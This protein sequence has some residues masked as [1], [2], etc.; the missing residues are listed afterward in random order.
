MFLV[1]ITKKVKPLSLNYQTQLK[2]KVIFQEIKRKFEKT[3]D[4]N[5]CTLE[6]PG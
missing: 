2:V 5:E 4:T 3:I 1:N 6:Q